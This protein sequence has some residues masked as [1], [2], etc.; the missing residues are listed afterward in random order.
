[1]ERLPD[2]PERRKAALDKLYD[3]LEEKVCQ[4]TNSTPR[5]KIYRVLAGFFPRD[6]HHGSHI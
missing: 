5:L 1:M 2:A 4:Y 6:F 3:E